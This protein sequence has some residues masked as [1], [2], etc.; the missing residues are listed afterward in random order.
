MRGHITSSFPLPIFWFD[1]DIVDGATVGA[2]DVGGSNA[3]RHG[4]FASRVRIH[5]ELSGTFRT[6]D[7]LS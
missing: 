2:W 4:E 3:Q 1:Q 5:V 7:V 6:A